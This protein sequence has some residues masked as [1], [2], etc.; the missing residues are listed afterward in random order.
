MVSQRTHYFSCIVFA[1][2]TEGDSWS[3]RILK[4]ENGITISLAVFYSLYTISV[5]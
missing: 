5:V 1:S 2:V 3:H 4:D